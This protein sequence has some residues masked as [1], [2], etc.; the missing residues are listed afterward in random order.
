M[1]LGCKV[2]Q[3]KF[4]AKRTL[5]GLIEL[6]VFLLIFNKFCVS[7]QSKKNSIFNKIN[8]LK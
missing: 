4:A 5:Y 8:A 7:L 2:K 6:A 3:N 1:L